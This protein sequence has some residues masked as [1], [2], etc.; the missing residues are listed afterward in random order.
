MA[1][2]KLAKLP[3]RTPVKM[4]ISLSPDLHAALADYAVVYRETYG[5]DEALGDLIPYM[6]RAFLDSD[7]RFAKAREALDHERDSHD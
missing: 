6:L 4:T 7:R 2:L 3:D 5:T 1:D